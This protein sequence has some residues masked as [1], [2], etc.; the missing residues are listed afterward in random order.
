MKLYKLLFLTSLLI[1]TTTGCKKFVESGNVNI[2]P[3]QPSTIT[4]NT[5]LPAVQYSTAFNQTYVA[6]ITSMFSQQMAAYSSGPINEDQNRDVRI[7][8]AYTGLYQNGMTNSKILI[9]LAA[10]LGSPHYAAIGRI[11]FVTNLSLATDT[12]GDVPLT[13]A[14]KSPEVL[15]PSYDSQESIYTFMQAY[16]DQAITEIGQTNP[17]TLKPG[18]DDL[19]YGGTMSKWK[20]TAYFLKARLFM[21]LTKKGAVTAANNAL[22]AIA[23]GFTPGTDYQ[24]IFSDKNPNPWHVTVSGRISGSAIFTIAPAQRFLN[25]TTG[26]T[27][28]GLFD[29]R[30]D[31]LVTK[32]GASPIYTGLNNGG[33]NTGVNN[34]DLRD[35]TFY[36]QKTSPLVIGSYAEQK[37]MEAEARFLVNGGT[38]SSK[39]STQAAYDAYKAGITANLTKLGIANPTAYSSHPQVDVGAANLT[40]ELIMRERQV[41][42]FLNPEAWTDMRRYDYNPNL[43]RGISLPLNQ[44]TEMNGNYIR[45]ALYPLDE[46]SRNP[47]AQASLKLMTDKVW[48]DQ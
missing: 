46:V 19:I 14:F 35:V 27:Y 25:A 44:N 9:D 4:L 31:R 28:P 23:N 39:G 7:T 6:Y 29:P 20:E 21:H 42:L 5:L 41:V 15:Y 37:L 34:T 11:L 32:S 40:L 12:W 10:S 2:N 22:T 24:L 8:T 33:G 47:K 16:L 45:R 18:I 30:I 17:A 36:A 1:I 38:T 26:V 13:E 43:F 3:N 48:W